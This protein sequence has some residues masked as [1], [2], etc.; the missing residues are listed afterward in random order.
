MGCLDGAAPLSGF[1]AV[2]GPRAAL[3]GSF[4]GSVA[5]AG[6]IAERGLQVPPSRPL[7]R[8][9]AGAAVPATGVINPEDAASVAVQR[10][11]SAISVKIAS[12][13]LHVGPGGFG[14]DKAQCHQSAGGIVDE[15]TGY[16][17]PPGWRGRRG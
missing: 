17:A 5:G 12:Q 13:G 11:R 1:S 15:Y 8:L 3:R 7:D 14:R 9:E 2:G 6:R 10:D 4:S 16:R